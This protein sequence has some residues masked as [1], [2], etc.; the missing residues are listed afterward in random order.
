[1]GNYFC[2]CCHPSPKHIKNIDITVIYCNSTLVVDTTAL[3][4]HSFC[5]SKRATSSAAAAQLRR[6][7]CGGGGQLGGGG[8]S[9]ASA[10][11]CRAAV[12][13]AAAWQQRGGGGGGGGGSLDAVGSTTAAW[14]QLRRWRQ[15]CRLHRHAAAMHRRVGNKDTGGDSGGGGTDLEI[16]RIDGDKEASYGWQKQSSFDS[17]LSNLIFIREQSQL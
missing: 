11:A 14:R 7:Q 1:M 13:A 3:T 12:S 6:G 17:N 15:R 2:N 8:G 16:R 4:T 5:C 9:A 10:V